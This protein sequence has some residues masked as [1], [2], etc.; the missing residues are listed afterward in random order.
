MLLD[1][2]QTGPVNRQNSCVSEESDLGEDSPRVMQEW[3]TDDIIDAHFKRAVSCLK[4][5]L[6]KRGKKQ[7]ERKEGKGGGE[8]KKKKKRDV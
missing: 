1:P 4:C 2:S 7:K 5:G 3:D 8:K 6:T